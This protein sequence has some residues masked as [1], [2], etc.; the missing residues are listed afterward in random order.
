MIL[1]KRTAKLVREAIV[2][3]HVH[4]VLWGHAFPRSS[5]EPYPKDSAVVAKVLRAAK[6]HRDLYP[7]LARVESDSEAQR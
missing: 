3:A 5:G 1:G 6:S 7:T 4:G 2:L